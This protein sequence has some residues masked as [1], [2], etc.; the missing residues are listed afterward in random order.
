MMKVIIFLIIAA[1]GVTAGWYAFGGQGNIPPFP[2]ETAKNETDQKDDSLP[3]PTLESSGL[4]DYQDS[5]T[6]VVPTSGSTF[7]DTT[8]GGV[9]TPTA[10]PTAKASPTV[11]VV[12]YTATVSYT[13]NGFSPMV[14]TVK[15]NTKVTFTNNSD[16]NMWVRTSASGQ[17]TDFDQLKSIARGGTYEFLF[18]S[19]GTW[20][21]ENRVTPEHTGVIIVTQ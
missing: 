3:Q 15:A 6:T 18:T 13:N 12:K 11:P 20:K 4:F 14:L 5:Q 9:V 2:I 16:K 7:S 8:K 17:L 10:K 1:L 21:Y 19:V